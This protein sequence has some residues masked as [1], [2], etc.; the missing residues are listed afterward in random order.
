MVPPAPPLGG[1][2]AAG[3]H[4]ELGP[5]QALD[6]AADRGV[7]EAEVA[8]GGRL[9]GVPAAAATAAARPRGGEGG[10]GGGGRGRGQ[11]GG[12]RVVRGQRAAFEALDQGDGVVVVLSQAAEAAGRGGASENKYVKDE[13]NAQRYMGRE[14]LER[15]TG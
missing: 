9:A 4:H 6:H 13:A 1:S 15:V 5:G 10:R 7:A 8:V 12:V 11:G 3:A 14:K 2:I